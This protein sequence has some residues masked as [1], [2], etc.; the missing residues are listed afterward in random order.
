MEGRMHGRG[1]C[2]YLDMAGGGLALGF[3]GSSAGAAAAGA[4]GAAAAGAALGASAWTRTAV[5]P[6]V[7]SGAGTWKARAD[8]ASRAR[9]RTERIVLPLFVC[10]YK[11]IGWGMG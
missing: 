10:L 2:T 6:T 11:C 4:A 1:T 3:G 9:A 7:W 8:E 5:R